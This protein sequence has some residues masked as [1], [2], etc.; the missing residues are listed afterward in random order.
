MKGL[1]RTMQAISPTLK[2]LALAGMSA[3]LLTGCA[4]VQ[5]RQGHIIDP[6]ISQA[7]APGVDNKASVSAS[8]GRPT[9][10]GTFE[11]DVWYY[12]SR[13]TRQLAFNSPKAVDQTVLRVTFDGNGT[14]AS[15]DRTG[16]ELVSNISPD[17]DKTRTMGRDRGFFEDL[18][19]NV[20]SVNSVGGAGGPGRTGP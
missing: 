18:F 20:G 13:D 5:G 17:G 16:L 4:R 1:V 9:F 7:I 3:L 11:E 15:V 10:E 8:M 2:M 14:V 19:G 12:V 6:V